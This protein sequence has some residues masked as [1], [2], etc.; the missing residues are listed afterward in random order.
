MGSWMLRE[1]WSVC[2]WILDHPQK[3][4]LH[5]PP[6][7]SVAGQVLASCLPSGWLPSGS[8]NTST[9]SWYGAG[10]TTASNS[11]RIVWGQLGEKKTGC[12]KV[13]PTWSIMKLY[14]NDMSWNYMLMIC[15]YNY[16][17]LYFRCSQS[18]W[19][20]S[21]F[22]FS[23]PPVRSV[24]LQSC[25]ASCKVR[26]LKG[27]GAMAGAVKLA[28][29]VTCQ[30]RHGW[31]LKNQPNTWKKYEGQTLCLSQNGILRKGMKIWTKP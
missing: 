13:D 22:W 5:R 15:H 31:W 26:H 28:C 19:V 4:L 10:S 25:A 30:E 29:R 16:L 18:F 27:R 3:I 14:V 21:N 17:K 8:G 2:N 1:L 11:A 23:K 9:S 20:C 6:S 7:F 12:P 24:L